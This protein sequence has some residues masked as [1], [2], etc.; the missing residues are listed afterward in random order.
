MDTAGEFRERD[1]I[2]YSIDDKWTLQASSEKETVYTIVF[3]TN[4][5]CRRVKKERYT[6]N[7]LKTYILYTQARSQ[8]DVFYAYVQASREKVVIHTH[9]QSPIFKYILGRKIEALGNNGNERK[10]IADDSKAAV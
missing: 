10:F 7:T 6:H 1:S 4:G 8:R 3:M 9:P 5:H 2:R